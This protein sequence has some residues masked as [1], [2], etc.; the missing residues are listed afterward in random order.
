MCTLLQSQEFLLYLG[1]FWLQSHKDWKSAFYHL[2]LRRGSIVSNRPGVGKATTNSQET[3]QII[4][5]GLQYVKKLCIQV[6]GHRSEWENMVSK[7]QSI[8]FYPRGWGSLA[9]LRA[10]GHSRTVAP[11]QFC[12]FA[13]SYNIS[14]K[15]RILQFKK[16]KPLLILTF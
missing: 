11:E 15:Q 12:F 6:E 2:Y 10:L 8:D 3:L 14:L 16:F 4:S 5:V 1:I 9:I 7:S 13:L